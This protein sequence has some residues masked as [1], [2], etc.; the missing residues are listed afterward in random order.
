MRKRASWDWVGDYPIFV[1]TTWLDHSKFQ[2]DI[3]IG[4]KGN[5]NAPGHGPNDKPDYSYIQ[6]GL[7]SKDE[8]VKA[9]FR[10]VKLFNPLLFLER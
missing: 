6:R 7:A 5:Q 8:V 3:I 10:A 1:Y 9:A 4:V 2:V